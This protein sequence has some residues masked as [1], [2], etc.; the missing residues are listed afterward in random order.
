MN[1]L[2]FILTP[3]YFDLKKDDLDSL[4]NH[5]MA[6]TPVPTDDKPIEMVR[7]AMTESHPFPRWAYIAQRHPWDEFDHWW[8][9]CDDMFTDR[10]AQLLGRQVWSLYEISPAIVAAAFILE[11]SVPFTTVQQQQ[12]LEEMMSVNDEDEY[13]YEDEEP[14]EPDYSLSPKEILEDYGYIPHCEQNMDFWGEMQYK[15]HCEEFVLI[16]TIDRHKDLINWKDVSA[17][18][19]FTP[20]LLNR[21]EQ[22]INWE[23]LSVNDWINW[24]I[25]SIEKYSDRLDWSLMSYYV[26]RGLA[27]RNP[28]LLNNVNHLFDWDI[29][30]SSHEEYDTPYSDHRVLP[31]LISYWKSIDWAQVYHEWRS[32]N[33][34]DKTAILV[35]QHAD[36]INWHQLS[37]ALAKEWDDSML[38]TFADHIDWT[39]LS[40]AGVGAKRRLKKYAHL[41][42]WPAY[43]A[44]NNGNITPDDLPTEIAIKYSSF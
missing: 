13:E 24:D 35:S 37:Q 11:M 33:N 34:S 17:Q 19:A 6:L 26:A 41:I 4:Y 21:Y 30:A 20:S 16:N 3:Q 12:M 36:V 5:I 31:F 15:E 14:Y 18:F 39:A 29:V 25:E 1:Q 44:S 23:W 22:Y 28:D 8:M 9:F 27:R 38:D 40:T 43:F 10:I 7:V 32:S 2:L 42:D